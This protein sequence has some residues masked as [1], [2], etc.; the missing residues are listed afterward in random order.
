[1]NRATA[2]YGKGLLNNNIQGT[3]TILDYSLNWWIWRQYQYIQGKQFQGCVL[4][5]QYCDTNR[6]LL[7][8]YIIPAFGQMQLCRIKVID[9]ERWLRALLE[10]QGLAPKSANNI[11][12][13]LSV[14]LEEAERLEII[15]RN[16]CKSVRPLVEKTPAKP[17]SA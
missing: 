12:S 3:V 8:R 14:M 5:Q 16:P 15:R 7:D 11:L 4:N 17:S 13:I 10:R 1:M 2:W 9:V 6:K